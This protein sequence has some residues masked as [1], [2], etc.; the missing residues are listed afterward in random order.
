MYSGQATD[1]SPT[2]MGFVQEVKLFRSNMEWHKKAWRKKGFTKAPFGIDDEIC[3]W[4]SEKLAIG[5]S[6]WKGVHRFTNVALRALCN[7]KS[8]H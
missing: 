6:T 8:A 7:E 5:Y 4:R 3:G 2:H 1:Y